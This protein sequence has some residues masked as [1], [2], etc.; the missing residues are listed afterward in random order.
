MP[1]DPIN[2]SHY[3]CVDANDTTVYWTGINSSTATETGAVYRWK[4]GDW[5]T[6][7][8]TSGSYPT[9]IVI[10]HDTV[11]IAGS[12]NTVNALPIARIAAWDGSNWSAYGQFDADVRRLKV[13]DD[14]LCAIGSFDTVD[15][16]AIMAAVKRAGQAWQPIASSS[17]SFMSLMDIVKYQGQ[18]AAVGTSDLPGPDRV[19]ISDNGTWQVLGAGISGSFSTAA[20]LEVFQNDLYIG[21]QISVNDG[22]AGQGVLRWDGTQ[23]HPLGMGLQISPGNNSSYCGAWE[24]VA[25]DGLLYVVNTCEYAGG[26]YAPGLATW[27]GTQWCALKGFFLEDDSITNWLNDIAFLN[28]TIY[29]ACGRMLDGVDVGFAAR[30]AIADLLDTCAVPTAVSALELGRGIAIHPNPASD[31]IRVAGD[32]TGSL[33]LELF[34]ASGRQVLSFAITSASREV[35]AAALAPGMYT[36]VVRYDEAGL[37]T[38]MLVIV[39]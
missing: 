26:L 21:G 23:F 7:A 37:R 1:G 35:D 2:P 19:F 34:D 18:Y 11:F 12:F 20:H 38:M 10:W 25:H 5:D 8:F 6:L 29:A 14:T 28:D 31:R 33:L 22:N 4:S 16:Q 15:G 32:F 3:I 30:A 17:A 9:G 24:L 39:R 13:V 36:V 27:D